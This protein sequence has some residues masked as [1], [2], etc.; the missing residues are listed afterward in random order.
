MCCHHCAMVNTCIS[1]VNTYKAL[2][3]NCVCQAVSSK[4][5]HLLTRFIADQN[6]FRLY[7]QTLAFLLLL[8][9]LLL[10]S[11]ILPYII[12]TIDYK[13]DQPGP[14]ATVAS[15]FSIIC[16]ETVLIVKFHI[17][18]EVPN[19]TRANNIKTKL[20]SNNFKKHKSEMS[21]A[22]IKNTYK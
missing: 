17:K 10:N 9:L 6:S 11:W 22:K 7:I 2:C 3:S 16:Q 8:T 20:V 14:S 1:G 21:F 18:G 12:P 5:F 15:K 4:Q 19:S 13:M